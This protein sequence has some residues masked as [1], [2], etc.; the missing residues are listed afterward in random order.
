[1]VGRTQE[2]NLQRRRSER[3]RL[4]VPVEVSWHSD[5]GVRNIENGETEIV[6]AHGLLVRMNR[7]LPYRHVV[8]VRPKH[9]SDWTLARVVW[10]GPEGKCAKVAM[11]FA[12]PSDELWKVRSAARA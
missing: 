11:E 6:S 9:G 5:P 12:T 2:V 3:L 10:C 7:P 8:S 4:A 1:M